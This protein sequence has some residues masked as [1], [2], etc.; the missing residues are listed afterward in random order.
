LEKNG[1]GLELQQGGTGE[2]SKY[3][4]YI[5]EAKSGRVIEEIK[6]ERE[7]EKEIER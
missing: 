2:S 5:Q 3:R 7:I 6:Q 4:C 1:F